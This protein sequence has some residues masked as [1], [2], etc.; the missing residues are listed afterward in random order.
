MTELE[1]LDAEIARIEARISFLDDQF[2]EFQRRA[3][4]LRDQIAGS[5]DGGQGFRLKPDSHSD[6]RRT[7]FR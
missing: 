3:D 5:D 7:A 2:F 6:R 4:Q 1:R